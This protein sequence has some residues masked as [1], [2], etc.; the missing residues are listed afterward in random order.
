MNEYS[1]HNTIEPKSMKAWV[2]QRFTEQ[3]LRELF[4]S[5]RIVMGDDGLI[6]FDE[7]REV[8]ARF[9]EEIMAKF[10]DADESVFDCIRKLESADLILQLMVICSIVSKA[11]DLLS[12]E[13]Q[14]V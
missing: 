1:N 10:V 9:P 11:R 6:D 12:D 3:E 5:K 8:L 2:K 7:T 4:D 14:I 13:D